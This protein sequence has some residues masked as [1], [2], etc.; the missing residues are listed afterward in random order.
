MTLLLGHVSQLLSDDNINANLDVNQV[1]Y[2]GWTA[3]MFAADNNHLDVV[4]SLLNHPGIDVNVQNRYNDT[5]LHWAV[6]KNHPAIV[7]QLLSDD[8]INVNLKGNHGRTPLKLAIYWNSPECVKILQ[9]YG[10][11]K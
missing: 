11:K 1:D 6:A 7:S 9:D 5:A 2:D 3:L 4:T 8:N 10:A